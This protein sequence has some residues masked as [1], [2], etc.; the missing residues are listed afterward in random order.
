VVVRQHT[1]RVAGQLHQQLVLLRREHDALTADGD[2][3][4]RS[5]DLNLPRL[6][7]VRLRRSHAPQHRADTR[8]QGLVSTC[9]PCN[10]AASGTAAPL[11]GKISAVSR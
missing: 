6:E 9:E 3:P 4:G 5:V 11:N 1:V 2:A 8:D 10:Q 7:A